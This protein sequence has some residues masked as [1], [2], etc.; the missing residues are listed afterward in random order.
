VLEKWS[1]QIDNAMRMERDEL[2]KRIKELEE[3]L[4][5]DI[6]EVKT[7][8]AH[9]DRSENMEWQIARDNVARKN[10][11]IARMTNKV[12][13]YKQLASH[14][15][16]TLVVDTGATVRLIEEGKDSEV[17]VKLVPEGLG[18]AEIGAIGIN[19]PVAKALIGR[20]AGET[21]IA[22]APIGDITL[23]IEEVY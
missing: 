22:R 4:Q 1:M 3:S 11:N 23:T 10:A 19:T 16:K 13:L 21:V 7:A 15:V 17:V 9:G 8:A 14:H 20:C 6:E 12:A 18:N 5:E 2:Y